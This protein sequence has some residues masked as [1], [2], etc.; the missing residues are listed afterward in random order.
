MAR[1][2]S[3]CRTFGGVEVELVYATEGPAKVPESDYLTW[4]NRPVVWW[5]DYES[6]Y[7]P[8]CRDE[9]VRR[10][11]EAIQMTKLNTTYWR[12]YNF[13]YDPKMTPEEREAYFERSLREQDAWHDAR[14][15][16]AEAEAASRAATENTGEVA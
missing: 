16:K 2:E 6:S 7:V 13:E 5:D 3:I 1:L 14:I 9:L 15:A 11:R 4:C 10:M 8:V 12:N